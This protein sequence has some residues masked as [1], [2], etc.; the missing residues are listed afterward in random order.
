MGY[1]GYIFLHDARAVLGEYS[2][3]F[4]CPPWLTQASR[5]RELLAYHLIGLA[6]MS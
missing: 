5:Q 1:M 4:R 2:E 6:C 3:K